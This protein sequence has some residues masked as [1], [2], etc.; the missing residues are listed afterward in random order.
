MENALKK[1]EAQIE[2]NKELR[3][4]V[5]QEGL[6]AIGKITNLLYKGADPNHRPKFGDSLICSVLYGWPSDVQAIGIELLTNFGGNVNLPDG[7]GQTA[8]SI[9]LENDYSAEIQAL[10]LSK[11]AVVIEFSKEDFT[12]SD[13]NCREGRDN[14]EKVPDA[15][16]KY[17]IATGKRACDI[18]SSFFNDLLASG[19]IKDFEKDFEELTSQVK[20]GNLSAEAGAGFFNYLINGKPKWCNNRFGSS[21]HFLKD[22]T[23]IQIGGEHEDY[24]DPEF[25]IY[26]DVIRITSDG[27]VDLFFYPKD[28]FPPTDFHSS[29]QL[30]NEILIIGGLGYQKERRANQTNMYALNLGDFSIKPVASSGNKPGWVFEHTT[31]LDEQNN[32]LYL[33]NG[34]K[35]M[36]GKIVENK[37]SYRLDLKNMHWSRAKANSN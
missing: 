22:G 9:C 1:H 21:H 4:L 17:M 19:K 20:A 7:Q 8:L 26:N 30:G 5:E 13:V 23:L 36:N 37:D 24:Y 33:I 28:V 16:H 25:N 12:S 35:W 15:Y 3:L 11:G 34:K 6:Q 27:S 31:F 18:G 14:P 2:L 29:I 10:L 32:C